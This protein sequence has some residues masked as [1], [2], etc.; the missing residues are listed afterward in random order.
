VKRLDW[1]RVKIHRNYDAAD[2]S[3]DFAVS[4]N[5]V[6][7]WR[8]AGLRPIEG[9]NPMLFLGPELRRFLKD[10]SAKRK[11]STPPGH[12][13]CMRCREPRRPAGKMV[14]YLPRSATNG[15]LEAMCSQCGAWM[16]RRVR[17]CDLDRVM[18]EIEVK[19]TAADERLTQPPRPSVNHDSNTPSA[20][21]AQTS[22]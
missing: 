6:W 19:V 15:N 4:R 3:R 2:I 12:I 10:R 17:L 9:N 5:T 21:H 1:R 7:N 8:K 20:P 14:D 22:S 13:F 11:R 16:L 18:P